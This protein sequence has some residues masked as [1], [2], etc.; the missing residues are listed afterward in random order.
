MRSQHLLLFGSFATKHPTVPREVQKQDS[1]NVFRTFQSSWCSSHL[2]ILQTRGG[3]AKPSCQPCLNAA[4]HASFKATF[5]LNT[6]KKAKPNP[7]NLP[8]KPA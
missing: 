7:Y 4:A 6:I 3:I 5:L 8:P 2:T 1:N